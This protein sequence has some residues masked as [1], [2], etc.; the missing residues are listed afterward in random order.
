LAAEIET[1]VKE[2][3]GM[4]PAQSAADEEAPASEE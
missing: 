3:L 2:Q 4:R 1:R